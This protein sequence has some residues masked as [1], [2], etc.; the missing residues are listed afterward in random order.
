MTT[1]G[2]QLMNQL[3]HPPHLVNAKPSLAKDA[4]LGLISAI[5]IGLLVSLVLVFVVLLLSTP[6]YANSRDIGPDVGVS[7]VQQGSL[8]FR[9]DK[10]GVFHIAPTVDTRVNMKVSGMIVRSTVVQRFSNPDDFWVEG[11]YVFPLPDDASVDHMRM[12]I[13]ERVVEGEIK[14]R[15]AARKTYEAA[16]QQGKKVALIDQQRPNVFT[17]AVAN[18]GPKESIVIEIEYQQVLHYENN[19]GEGKFEVRFPMTVTPRYFPAVD[20][21]PQPDLEQVPQPQT[22]ALQPAVYK[23]ERVGR[24]NRSGWATTSDIIADSERMS[25]P[26]IANDTLDDQGHASHAIVNPVSINVELNTGFPINQIISPYHTIHTIRQ[27]QGKASIQLAQQSVAANRD[28]DLVWTVDS[29]YAPRAAL[30]NEEQGGKLYNLIMVMPPTEGVA[31]NAQVAREV[32]YIID[33]SGSMEGTSLQQAKSAL[34]MALARLRPADTFN[35]VQFNSVTSALF[36]SAHLANRQNIQ[37]AQNYVNRLYATGGTEM[38]PALRQAFDGVVDKGQLRQVIFLTDGSV[39]NESQLFDLIKSKLGNSRLFTI[40]IGSA[41]NSYFMTRAAEFGRGTY[42]YVGSSNEVQT[43]MQDLFTK[44]ETPVLTDLKV[45]LPD[46]VHAEVWP[47]QI[48]DLY[49]GEPVIIAIQSQQ[50]E[51]N[52]QITGQRADSQWQVELPVRGGQPG[53]GVG[54]L[55]ARAKIKDLM[56]DMAVNQGDGVQTQNLKKSIIDVALQHHLVSKYTSLVAVDKTPTRAV[57]DH[58]NTSKIPNQMPYGATMGM[59]VGSFAKTATQAQL[60]IIIGL[61]LVLFS[62]LSVWFWNRQG[63]WH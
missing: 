39:G 36:D 40:G 57:W 2:E 11:I 63:A 30:F 1:E 44:L 32:I 21:V 58:L 20:H 12:K 47:K 3:S 15:E 17:N 18:I 38:L 24:F 29:G 37:Q 25:P 50:L 34:S 43:K 4:L 49:L 13:G 14:E 26:F 52:V 35:I 51:G 28:F 5:S 7:D 53:S 6:S 41:P 56:N 45:T 16:K 42:T 61:A 33:T 59:V 55:W 46:N 19:K 54:V 23:V 60:D 48:P 27:A 62:L 22:P 8:L 31:D 10:P 9:T